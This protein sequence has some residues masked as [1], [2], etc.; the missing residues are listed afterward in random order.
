M[1]TPP[2]TPK[3]TKTEMIS[4]RTTPTLLELLDRLAKRDNTDRSSVI[5][6]RLEALQPATT[7]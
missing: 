5:R 2:T 1:P 6:E 7:R 3:T 4:F